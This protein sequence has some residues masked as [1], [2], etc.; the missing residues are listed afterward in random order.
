M[1]LTN[2]LD[3]GLPEHGRHAEEHM[4]TEQPFVIVGR[5]PCTLCSAST[6]FSIARYGSAPSRLQKR[7]LEREGEDALTRFR[8][9]LL[10]TYG[11]Q[12]VLCT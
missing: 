7:P 11:V 12:Q 6:H 3:F 2:G 9:A 4:K 8:Y 1:D 10:A 5:P